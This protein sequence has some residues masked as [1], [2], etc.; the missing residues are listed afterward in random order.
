[1]SF[2][3]RNEMSG[4]DITHPTIAAQ[5]HPTKNGDMKPSQFTS[6]SGK[7]VWWACGKTC[8]QGCPHEWKTAIYDRC[9]GRSCPYC[10]QKA[11]RCEHVS[12]THTHPDIAAQWHPTKNNNVNHSQFTSGSGQKVWW[13]CSNTCPRGCPHEWEASIGKR[14]TGRGCP[15]CSQRAISC[16]HV[17]ITYT[18]PEIAEQ[19]H[20]TKNGDL[21]PS[22]FTPGSN[23]KV[24]WACS[25]TCPQGCQ[26][27]WVATIVSRTA[28]NGCPF[29]SQKATRCEHVSITY[30][31]LEVAAQ[32]HPTKNGGVKPSQFTSGSG[33]KI[34]WI[35][36]QKSHEWAATINNRCGKSGT[37]CP[38]C[39]NKTEAQLHTYLNKLFPDLKAQF[40]V[41]WCISPTS[42]KHLP[43]DFYIPSL[44][45]I[46]ELDGPQHF[47]QI[48]N[49]QCHRTTVKGDVF[50]MQRA[51]S[52]GISV[53]RLVQ[54]EI[55]DATPEWLEMHVKPH[56]V[57]NEISRH[58]M[59]SITDP[60][61]Y[62]E[63][64]RLLSSGDTMSYNESDACS[65]DSDNNDI[66][67]A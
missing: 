64:M 29:C 44:Q 10:S 36:P 5:W 51:T 22:H 50:K 1:M 46:I 26:H 65:Q 6:G 25:N 35:C 18:H 28:G 47:R 34:W 52:A 40:R 41:S 38:H 49:W 16:E 14:C 61:L 19:W 23:T 21:N 24:W 15:F 7:K 12:I 42:N 54:E 9:A 39:K 20:P 53:I 63:H 55:L 66:L 8:P 37:G 60:T 30:T 33:K 58:T 56:L 2:Y 62:S 17:S 32:W 3:T 67:S 45:L 31:H 11:I 4:I 27:E 43:F 13:K 48:S 57:H 59:I